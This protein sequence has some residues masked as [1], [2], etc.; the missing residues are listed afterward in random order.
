MVTV[1]ESEQRATDLF[2][3]KSALIYR[4]YQEQLRLNNAMDFDDLLLKPIELFQRHPDVAKKYRERFQF[5]FVDE[6][7]DTNRAQYLLLKELA[8]RHRNI[9]VV[10]DDAQSIYAFRGADIRNML[11]FERDYPDRKIFRLE[12]NYRSTRAILKA[13]DTLIKNNVDQIQK[14]L[15]TE[16]EPGEPVT[17]LACTDEVDEARAI[18][19]SLS[20]DIQRLKLN[21]RDLAIL[22]RTNAQSRALEEGLR[23]ES[24]PYTI[25]GGLEFYQRKEIKDILGYFKVFTNPKD[26][27]SFLRIVNTPVRGIG[28]RALERFRAF[29]EERSLSFAEAASVAGECQGLTEKSRVGFAWLANYMKKFHDLRESTSLNEL[30]RMMI[31]DIGVLGS[32]KTEGTI[33]SLGRWDNIQELL[34]GISEFASRNP[35]ALLEDFLENVALVSDLDKWDDAQNS[36]TLMTLH[37][38]KGL[39]FPLVAI[40]GMEEGLVPFSTSQL[41]RKN[42]EEERRLCYVGMTRAMKKLYLSYARSRFRHGELTTML[43]SRFLGEIGD[44]AMLVARSSVVT[45]RGREHTAIRRGPW[46]ERRA[47]SREKEQYFQDVMPDY[48]NQSDEAERLAPGMIVQHETFGRGAVVA[49]QGKGEQAKVV[50]EFD[51]VGRKNLMLKYARLSKVNS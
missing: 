32:L 8:A 19:A 37:S 22:Y 2:E 3:E 24:I 38:A 10:G 41:E 12:Q 42:L 17:V 6:Y 40:A 13:A 49:M 20:G 30:A 9:C 16:N 15:W 21:F 18:I 45:G 35:E 36:V 34:S 27:E 23:N 28:E 26:N 47:P 51:S 48:E 29:A 46:Q 7:Q 5:I 43:P 11:D 14:D 33:E 25:V 44:G 4:K 31:D 50:V 1:E 39:E